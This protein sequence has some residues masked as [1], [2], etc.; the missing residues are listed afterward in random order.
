[1]AGDAGAAAFDAA[2][3]DQ[4]I[5]ELVREEN[6]AVFD[7]DQRQRERE[8]PAAAAP[9]FSRGFEPLPPVVLLLRPHGQAIRSVF[10]PMSAAGDWLKHANLPHWRRR[11]DVDFAFSFDVDNDDDQTDAH[12]PFFSQSSKNQSKTERRGRWRVL[13]F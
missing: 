3:Y 1:M 2:A 13:L 11:R 5:A 4:K 9:H 10:C 6:L 7:D 12:G 8:E